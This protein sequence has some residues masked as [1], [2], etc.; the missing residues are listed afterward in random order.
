MLGSGLKKLAQQ[1][2]MTVSGGMAYG[3]VDG[4]LVSFSEGMGEKNV[5]VSAHFAD[6]NGKNAFLAHFQ[7]P[8]MGSIYRLQHFEMMQAGICCTFVDNPGT[9]KRIQAFLP[10]L[11]SQLSACG[12]AGLETCP[13]CGNALA[14][15]GRPYRIGRMAAIVHPSCIDT[16]S[17]Q[18]LEAQQEQ[19]LQPKRIGRGILGAVLGAVVGAIPWAIVY[20]LGWFVGWLGLL[21][22]FLATKGYELLGGG[23]CKAKVIIIILATVLGVV[24][25]NFLGDYI[26]LVSMVVKGEVD[27]A[28]SQLHTF[29]FYL[30]GASAEYRTDFITNCGLGLLFAVLGCWGVFKEVGKQAATGP[31]IAPL[32]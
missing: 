11:T 17:Q 13:I 27:L 25:G 15:T 2:G 31:A 8:T 19:R 18:A 5:C 28:F 21:I 32:N 24:L 10:E 1:L 12:A 26:T 22:G 7:A 4:Y 6:E 14:G 29:I 23:R 9:L 30:L 16:I 3:A 20:S